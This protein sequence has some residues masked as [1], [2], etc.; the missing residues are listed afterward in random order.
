MEIMFY[1]KKIS[2]FK[3]TFIILAIG[4]KLVKIIFKDLQVFWKGN[5][6][7]KEKWIKKDIFSMHIDI[8][9]KTEIKTI[10]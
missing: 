3:I 4:S 7:K 6:E 5:K 1:N 10:F 8:K 2:N 9:F